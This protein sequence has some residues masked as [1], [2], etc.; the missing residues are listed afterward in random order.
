MGLS[1]RRI[2][3]TDGERFIVLVDEDG[4][5]LFYPAL[6]VTESPLNSWTVDVRFWRGRNATPRQRFAGSMWPL[7]RQD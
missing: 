5:P 6:Y 1:L 3:S 2:K 7:A 4:M